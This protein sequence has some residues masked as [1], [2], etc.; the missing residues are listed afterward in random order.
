MHD[1]TNTLNI[2][3]ILDLLVK[4]AKSDSKFSI[5]FL[6][7]FIFSLSFLFSIPQAIKKSFWEQYNS[8]FRLIFFA[9]EINSSK[10]T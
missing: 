6:L 4:R 9:K 5:I 3:P 8:I 1:T 10:L 2:S 7:L